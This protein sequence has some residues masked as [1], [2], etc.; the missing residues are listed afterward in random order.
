MIITTAEY[1][2]FD[3]PCTL[4]AKACPL[5]KATAVL[6]PSLFITVKGSVILHATLSLQ[7]APM[8]PCTDFLLISTQYSLLLQ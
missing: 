7:A 8:L 1:V 3:I 5:C 2:E 6:N 4:K